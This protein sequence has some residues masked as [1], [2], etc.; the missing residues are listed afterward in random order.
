M[1]FSPKASGS[2][3]SKRPPIGAGGGLVAGEH[4]VPPLLAVTVDE[5]STELGIVQAI[6]AVGLSVLL[7]AAPVGLAPVVLE[8]KEV[9]QVL[10]G[11]GCEGVAASGAARRVSHGWFCGGISPVLRT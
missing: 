8:T 5:L 10:T 6:K 2:P 1:A 9:D 4:V 7:A 3:A 11:F